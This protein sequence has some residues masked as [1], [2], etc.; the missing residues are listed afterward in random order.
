VVQNTRDGKFSAEMLSFAAAYNIPAKVHAQGDP[1]LSPYFPVIIQGTGKQTDGY[2]L[3]REVT[4]TFKKQGEYLV[5]MVIVTDGI[6]QSENTFLRESDWDTVNTVNIS[7][8]LSYSSLSNTTP[9]NSEPQISKVSA[10]I[11]PSQ[12]GFAESPALWTR[13]SFRSA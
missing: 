9:D 13:T 6:G 10:T 2:W 3:V 7:E 5:D 11:L 4:H 8:M 1:R 12:Q